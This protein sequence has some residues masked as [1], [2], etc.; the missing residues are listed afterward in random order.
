MNKKHEQPG[1][2]SNYQASVL[3]F[4]DCMEPV[5]HLFPKDLIERLSKMGFFA[6]PA[7]T[8]HHGAYAGGLFEHSLQVTKVLSILTLENG[9]AWQRPESPYIV[10]MFHDI[11][12]A[13]AYRHP[14]ADTILHRMGPDGSEVIRNIDKSTWEHDT[15]SLLKGHGDKSVMVLSQF[16]Q[17]TLEEILCIRYHMGAFVDQKEWGDYTRAVQKFDTVLWTHHADMIATHILGK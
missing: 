9:L 16:L 5:L 17:L 3:R 14:Y 6:A 7:S 1:N 12:K 10:G 13:D 8:K 4:H 15:T 2:D 11:C